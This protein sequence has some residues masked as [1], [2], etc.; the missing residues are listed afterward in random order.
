[1]YKLAALALPADGIFLHIEYNLPP[2]A[3]L[4]F[5]TT[6]L[7]AVH[8]RS[9]NFVFAGILLLL[10]E[11][12]IFTVPAGR[13]GYKTVN[14]VDSWIDAVLGWLPYGHSIIALTLLAAT[15]WF[16]FIDHRGEDK[17]PFRPGLLGYMWLESLVWALL[18]FFN[19]AFLVQLI[20][21]V[22]AILG[23]QIA[24]TTVA[25]PS[26]YHSIGLSLG[27]GFYEELFFRLLLVSAFKALFG[28]LGWEFGGKIGT[29]LVIVLL[30]AG[31]FSL[32]HH[33]PPYGEPLAMWPLLFRFVFGILMS[34]L[35][36]IRGF[37]VVAWTHAL[38]DVLIDVRG[39]F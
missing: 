27:A 13:S 20:P 12:I 8:Q 16:V 19:L 14:A 2:S 39:L 7:K 32:A 24:E 21:G 23:N 26:F 36:L 25:Q 1:V 4:L 31:L 9:Y 33:I 11:L 38:Y 18:L 35:L 34:G 10:Y 30:T 3:G 17:E 28:I 6:Y 5:V 37:G 29:G 15:A 22:P